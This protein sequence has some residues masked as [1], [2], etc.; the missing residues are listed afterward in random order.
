M[1][2]SRFRYVGFPVIQLSVAA[3]GLAG[4]F[5]VGRVGK[6]DE[7]SVAVAAYS[8]GSV[9][10]L[11]LT[12]GL[13]FVLPNY[14]R[15]AKLEGHRRSGPWS[16]V[17]AVSVAVPLAVLVGG[18]ISWSV[19]LI[20][21][22]VALTG[23]YAA[24]LSLSMTAAQLARVRGSLTSLA[25]SLTPQVLLPF[26]WLA[27]V[28]LL[29][30]AN[31]NVVQTVVAL[32]GVSV[33][34]AIGQLAWIGAPARAWLPALRVVSRHALPL[35]PHMLAFAFLLQAPRILVGV[36][37]SRSELHE[38]HL[39]L[40]VV[41]AAA[42]LIASFNSILV[43]HIQTVSDDDFENQW[44]RFAWRY[45][46]IG[47]F[48]SLFSMAAIL[49]GARLG[50]FGNIRVDYS[51]GVL[52]ASVPATLCCYYAVS[53]LIVRDAK[54]WILPCASG[55][56]ASLF[57]GVCL[58]HHEAATSA[59]LFALSALCLPS[60]AVGLGVMTVAR[61]RRYWWRSALISASSLLVFG[62]VAASL[63]PILA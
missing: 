44:K 23:A 1:L 12:L 18:L 40:L 51:R 16:P 34:L 41:N 55:F 36:L 7:Q 42:T 61:A 56:S 26:L 63:L 15:G 24:S 20:A 9:L 49:G 6:A 10:G 2:G 32:S 33:L 28:L 31:A 21:S 14:F 5:L 45:A 39:L 35:L 47:L 54:T 27:G 11:V 52:L 50:L 59:G 60:V 43:V 38:M 4:W 37:G 8:N 48:T 19:G 17:V 22:T 3:F 53:S 29:L 30:S 13:P 25:L 58:V 62:V 46:G 57:V